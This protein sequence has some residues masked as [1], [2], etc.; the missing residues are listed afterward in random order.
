MAIERRP[1]EKRLELILAINRIPYLRTHEKCRLLCE[2]RDLNDIRTLSFTGL[3]DIIKDRSIPAYALDGKK[4]VAAAQREIEYLE[5]DKSIE[6]VDVESFYYPDLLKEIFNPPF[7]LYYRGE[8]PLSCKNNVAVV[9]TRH[10]SFSSL[11]ESFLFGLEWGVNGGVVVSG[12]ANGIDSAAHKG[13]LRAGGKTLAVLGHGIDRVYPVGNQKLA[14][15]IIEQGGALISE[16]SPGVPPTRYTFPQRNRIISGL[17]RSVIIVQAPQKSG[18]LITA[19]FALDQGRD[20]YVLPCGLGTK[21]GL[22]GAHL[23]EEGAPLLFDY[24]TLSSD[25]TIIRKWRR[26]VSEGM[27]DNREEIIEMIKKDLNGDFIAYAGERYSY[28]G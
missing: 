19:D 4:I 28:V 22:G 5:K 16:F 23:Y 6:V 2:C 26:V 9:G 11:R 14:Y 1:S 17:S 7:L 27:P 15:S 25:N 18:A 12:L 3:K 13:N 20:L 24:T 10:A 21:R 8:L